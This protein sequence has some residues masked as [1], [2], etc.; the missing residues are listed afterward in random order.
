MLWENKGPFTR[1]FHLA[2]YAAEGLS[3][4]IRTFNY[5]NNLI[6]SVNLINEAVKSEVCK[7]FIFTSSIAAYGEQEPPLHE[8]TNSVPTDPYGIAKYAVEMDLKAAYEMWGLNS[9]IFRP[10]NIYGEKQNIMDPY[11]NVV[12]I[13]MRCAME[14]KSFPIFG[15]GM[16]TRAFSYVR[17]ISPI[18][19]E[20][21]FREDCFN[22]T[23]NIGSDDVSTVK[24]LAEVVSDEFGIPLKIDWLEERSEAKHAFADH[25]KL[26]KFFSDMQKTGLEEGISKM[27]KW[28]RNNGLWEASHPNEVEVLRCLPDSWRRFMKI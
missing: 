5:R 7:C 4:F 25:L 8:T 16:Q 21:G 9:V 2:A 6:G 11:R 13:F 24:Y 23:F 1:V 14:G 27:S 3:H 18:I 12:G 10:H 28:V 22:E 20:S 17:D 19:V 15:N 26:E